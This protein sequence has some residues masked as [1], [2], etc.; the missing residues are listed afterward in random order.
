MTDPLYEAIY[1]KK[2]LDD[3]RETFGPFHQHHVDLSISTKAMLRL[4]G[5]MRKK[6]RRGEVV[7]VIPND[8]GRLWLHTKAFYPKGVYR[9]MTGGIGI[10]EKPPQTMKRETVE[11]TGFSVDIDRCLA[12]IT[13]TLSGADDPLSFV[14]YAFLTSPTNGLPQPTDTNE[15]ISD[16][17]AVSIKGLLKAGR[18]LCSIEGRFADWGIFRAIAHEI[19]GEILSTNSNE[20]G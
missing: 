4:V 7:M 12:V 9:L 3:L 11:E 1:N 19:V 8:R 15:A 5:K 10:G 2:I 18:Q 20:I 6:S 17:R 16:F 14:S 13:Y